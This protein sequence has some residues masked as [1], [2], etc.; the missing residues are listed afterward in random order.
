MT[1]TK[2]KQIYVNHRVAKIF[3]D[4]VKMESK[5]GRPLT[6]RRAF[7]EAMILWANLKNKPEWME[8]VS[9]CLNELNKDD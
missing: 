3:E 1:P 5:T 7:E 4:E 8:K 9:A 2:K 6:Q